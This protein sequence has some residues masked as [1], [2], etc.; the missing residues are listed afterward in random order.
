MGL[1]DEGLFINSSFSSSPPLSPRPQ[2]KNCLIE[3]PRAQPPSGGG[4]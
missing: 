2:H 3:L 4:L 1:Q